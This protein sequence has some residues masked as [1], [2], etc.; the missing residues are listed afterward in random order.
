MRST[1][2]AVASLIIFANLAAACSGESRMTVAEYARWCADVGSDIGDGEFAGA[3]WGELEDHLQGITDELRNIENRI[4]DEDSLF[5]YHRITRGGFEMIIKAAQEQDED[6]VVDLL[7]I[8]ATTTRALERIEAAEN[9]LSPKTYTALF[10]TG[11]IAT[12]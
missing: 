1:I 5:T 12:N 4:P 7:A 6:E 2:A 9:S 11:C 10:N 8:Y 3:T